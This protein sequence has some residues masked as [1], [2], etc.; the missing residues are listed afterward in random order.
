MR[1]KEVERVRNKIGKSLLHF[2]L[3]QIIYSKVFK[4]DNE[5]N[6]Y[7]KALGSH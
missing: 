1:E 4:Q 7:A 5:L 6:F 3:I 2:Y